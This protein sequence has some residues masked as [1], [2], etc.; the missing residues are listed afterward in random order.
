MPD[1]VTE[2]ASAVA[3]TKCDPSGREWCRTA[4]WG[5]MRHMRDLERGDLEWRPEESEKFI[6]FCEK[7]IRHW[8][9]PLAG[10]PLVL[11][12]WQKLALGAIFG[13][14][15]PDGR[16]R[17]S[18][19][20]IC[21]PRGSGKTTMAAV[22]PIFQM[23]LGSEPAAECYAAATKSEQARLLFRDACSYVRNSPTL[24]ELLRVKQHEI[25]C[26]L[27]QGFL[28]PMASDAQ[29]ADGLNIAVAIID[30]LHAH[31]DGELYRVLCTS[32]A[33]RPT[34]FL[35][36]ITTAGFS[37]QSFCA[38]VHE[39][40]LKVLDPAQNDFEN[41]RVNYAIWGMDDPKEWRKPRQWFL[42][43]PQLGASLS[44]ADFREAVETCDVPPNTRRELFVKRLNSWTSEDTVA[45]I[46]NREWEACG[47]EIAESEFEGRQ[48]FAG[49]DLAEVH[50]LSALVVIY[51]PTREGDR[52]L[53]RSTFWCPAEGILDRSRKDQV[54]YEKWARAGILRTIPGEVT[55]FNW[56]ERDLLE[57]AE[58]W[59]YRV[60]GADPWKCADLAH[61]LADQGVET[62]AVRQGF[63]TQSPLCNELKRL[64]MGGLLAHGDHPI[65]SWNRKN[66]A[67][68]LDPSGNIKLDKSRSAERIDGMAALVNAIGV[69]GED[70]GVSVYSAAGEEAGLFL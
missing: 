4:Q 18:Q 58:K 37:N 36:A 56:V 24:S 41:D 25:T 11:S 1:T 7:Y 50:D 33:K 64:V 28:K 39:A 12:P 22:L 59:N 46:S 19:S 5:A 29:T 67:V 32:L 30:E 40:G 8:K 69:A 65:L 31:R 52:T 51:P 48:G 10:T 20:Y 57:L 61:R 6:S 35:T 9:G 34:S 21:V 55:D 60:I 15:M 14:W 66:V 54:P 42:S 27:T 62:V 17:F 47:G 70:D 68:R 16:R 3:E 53:V 38:S 45:W 13:W 44:E 26:A 63:V 43:N 23:T 2:I 49:L